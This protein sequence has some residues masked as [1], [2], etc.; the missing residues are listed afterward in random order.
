MTIHL[1]GLSEIRGIAALLVLFSHI[2]QF[3]EVL[4]LNS[5][6]F[7]ETGIA[8]HAVTIFFTLSGFL[9]T[10]LLLIEDK[11][12]NEI[13]IKKFYIRR[14]LRIWPA[15]YLTILFSLI[16]MTVGFFNTPPLNKLIISLGGYT[17]MTPNILYTFG[18]TLA[19]TTP[20][21]S[22]GVEEQFYLI[23]P[24]IVNKIS[25]LKTFLLGLILFYVI[26]KLV[27]FLIHPS[28]GAYA[29]VKLTRFDCMA[30][31]ALIPIFIKENYKGLLSLIFQPITQLTSIAILISPFFSNVHFMANIEIEIYAISSTIWIANVALN[32]K[33]I[34]S[35]KSSILRFFGKISY[36]I[37]VYHLIIIY[38][39]G[40]LNANLNTPITYLIVLISVSSFATLSYYFIETK[41]IKLKES[42]SIIR[43]HG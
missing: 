36:G 39:I 28:G 20:L 17:L 34:I 42:Y 23:W 8:G 4:H 13:H 32:P 22:I 30:F 24:I 25:N 37:Y 31:G 40:S 6:G 5:I 16:L 12:N 41:F 26:T 38:L 2:D 15:Y 11:K 27:I 3:H 9:I 18:L 33:T 35:I 1:K 7:S 14:I 10:H 43:S 29:L 21:W 19:G